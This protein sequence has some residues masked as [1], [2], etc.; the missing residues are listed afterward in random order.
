MIANLAKQTP[1]LQIPKKKKKKQ[2]V[3]WMAAKGKP[4]V[5]T[6][7]VCTYILILRVH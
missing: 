5:S 6:M 3:T 1:Q 4:T 2:L 7:T